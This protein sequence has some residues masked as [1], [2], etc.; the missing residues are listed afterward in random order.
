MGRLTRPAP[1]SGTERLD[2]FDSGEPVLDDWLRRHAAK[3]EASGASR[4]FVVCD[5][6]RRVAGYYALATGAVT[7]AEAP[8]A[9]R[10]NM[11]EPIPVLVLGRLAVDRRWQ[12]KG[13]GRGLLRDATLRTLLVA[14]HAGVR[15]LLIHAISPEAR[16]FYRYHG[17]HPSPID[18]M[19]LMLTTAEMAAV[20]RKG[21]ES[22]P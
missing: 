1:L 3:N 14:Q 18:P 6:R 7:R 13:V 20:L 19:T 16:R 21:G 2:D 4:T 15:A 10:R 22:P 5:A 17:F 12:G 8:G 11:P 9:V